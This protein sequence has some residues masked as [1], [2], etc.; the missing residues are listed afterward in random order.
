MQTEKILPIVHLVDTEGPLDEKIEATFESLNN[1]FG[2]KLE[3]TEENLKAIQR[4]EGLPD[5]L[6]E[7]IMRKYSR[8][9]LA[10][11]RNWD[12]IEKM[13]RRL[14]NKDWRKKFKDSFGN[15][16]LINWCCVDFLGFEANPR[17]RQMGPN[18]IFKYYEKWIKD[19]DIT[20]DKLYWH[21]HPVA[22]SRA[23]HHSGTSLNHFPYHYTS[24]CHRILDCQNFPAVFRPGYHTERTD[25]NIFLE[26]WIPFDYANQNVKGKQMSTNYGRLQNWDGAPTDW[27]V[28]H[29][30]FRDPRKKGN[31]K[32]Q[33]ARCLNL[34]TDFSLLTEDE[35]KTAFCQAAK[36]VPVI[37]S[38]AD[39]D[40]RDM[41]I[42]IEHAAK[43]IES[44]ASKYKNKVKFKYCSA[45]EAMRIIN[46]YPDDGKLEIQ[47]VL[48]GNKL[49]VSLNRETFG[50]QP[51]LAIKTRKGEVLHDNFCFG[52]DEKSFFYIFDDD[53]IPLERVLEIGVGA[54]DYIGNSTVSKFSII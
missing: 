24:L 32:R 49:D 29:P 42:E 12:D 31:M 14:F 44:V 36:G 17:K 45:V 11:N 3:P 19:S 40:E 52:K 46:E 30:N 22:F 48:S 13:C 16:Y 41:V 28:Y 50:S 37:L 20:Q 10:Y 8:Q 4:G 35:V 7:T 47:L 18:I 2:I 15:P 51:F 23:A 54:N 5:S 38:Y 34:G 43:M 25:L 9:R 53:S 33:I 27:T 26:Q 39:H 6:R 1:V 21:Y